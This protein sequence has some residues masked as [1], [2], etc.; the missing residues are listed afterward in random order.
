MTYKDKAFCASPNCDNKCGRKLSLED[1]HYLRKH[2]WMTV[3][4]SYF[5]H[6]DTVEAP[7]EGLEGVVLH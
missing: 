2:P 4:M 6:K 7:L 3:A 1:K 5:C